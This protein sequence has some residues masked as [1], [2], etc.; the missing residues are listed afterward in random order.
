MG[1]VG[2]GH[3]KQTPRRCLLI[4]LRMSYYHLPAGHEMIASLVTELG[5]KKIGY[6]RVVPG[7]IHKRLGE[8]AST[9][10]A[11]GAENPFAE[12]EPYIMIEGDGVYMIAL[13]EEQAAGIAYEKKLRV[14]PG[15]NYP[16]DKW[17]ALLDRQIK[18]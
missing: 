18:Q 5:E 13:N 11:S 15:F 8:I 16:G 17:Q 1:E 9:A 10:I 6:D 3:L 14:R 4:T 2:W 12:I 7:K